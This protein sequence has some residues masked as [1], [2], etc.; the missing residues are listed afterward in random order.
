MATSFPLGLNQFFRTLR[1][2]RSTFVLSENVVGNITGGG[3][4]LTTSRGNRLWSGSVNVAPT[5]HKNAASSLAMVRLLARPGAS[6]MVA[7]VRR[8]GVAFDPLG[9]ILGGSTPQ[10]SS[11]AANNLDIDISGLPIGYEL[12]AGDRLSF[13]YG[14]PARFALHEVVVGG[15]ADAGGNAS[16]IEVNPPIRPGIS[17]PVSVNLV[18][19]ACKAVMTPDSLREPSFEAM[20]TTGWSFNWRQSL[21]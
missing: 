5:S 4:V 14:T 6:F 8:K 2:P 1:V 17:T 19:A 13:E 20:L 21:R 18:D 11:V 10:V 16:G 7:D 9:T 3:E 12:Q 15:V